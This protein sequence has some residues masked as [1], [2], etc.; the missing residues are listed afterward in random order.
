MLKTLLKSIVL[1]LCAIGWFVLLSNITLPS[2][3]ISEIKLWGGLLSITLGLSAW[4]R[5][6]LR[7]KAAQD[8]YDSLLR[9]VLFYTFLYIFY[10]IVFSVIL[11]VLLHIPVSPLVASGF[12]LPFLIRTVIHTQVTPILMAHGKIA[13]A[14]RYLAAMQQRYPHSIELAMQ[15][16]RFARERHDE[17]AMLVEMER[18]IARYPAPKLFSSTGSDQ[19]VHPLTLIYRERLM[20]HLSL[21]HGEQALADARF[22]VSLKHELDLAFIHRGMAFL[23]VN[24]LDA[25]AADLE[26]ALKIT[27]ALQ[28]KVMASISLGLIEYISENDEQAEVHWSWALLTNDLLPKE[29]QH[30]STQIFI[31]RGLLAFHRGDTGKAWHAYRTALKIDP[32]SI[33][34]RTGMSVLHAANEHWDKALKIWRELLTEYPYFADPDEVIRRYFRWTPPMAEGVRQITERLNPSYIEDVPEHVEQSRANREM[35]R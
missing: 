16:I 1:L 13:Q 8:A 18:I 34:G 23:L 7:S 26:Q 15:K 32:Q 10:R 2:S 27:A 21:G 30:Y 9:V 5:F 20:L 28:R 24:D 3:L 4:A 25:A 22:I 29:K 14:T 31:N 17:N 19:M 12:V 33:E 35:V 11:E 6:S